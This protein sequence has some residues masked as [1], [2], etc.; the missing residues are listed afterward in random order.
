MKVCESLRLSC[1]P[2][3]G[4]TSTTAGRL[5]QPCDSCLQPRVC[6]CKEDAATTAMDIMMSGSGDAKRELDWESDKLD[7]TEGIAVTNSATLNYLKNLTENNKVS[8]EVFR[9]P[10]RTAR[11]NGSTK[12]P[13]KVKKESVD[14]K[15]G[16]S[17]AG[18]GLEDSRDKSILSTNEP[19]NS[20]D[21]TPTYFG[22]PT[23]SL[24]RLVGSPSCTSKVG[25]DTASPNRRKRPP[26]YAA[27]YPKSFYDLLGRLL[28]LYPA[29]RISA[30]QALQHPFLEGARINSNR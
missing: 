24:P 2:E 1:V 13:L 29:S 12:T 7:A 30:E 22:T 25:G 26:L 15:D 5:K 27:P 19:S 9:S 16:N 18:V 6:V 8:R 3:A 20:K 28:D 10:L 21:V 23:R 14:V 4:G 17:Y 11:A